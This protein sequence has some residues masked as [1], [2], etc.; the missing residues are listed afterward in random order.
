MTLFI[1]D[2]DGPSFILFSVSSFVIMDVI[3]LQ[4]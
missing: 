4:I 2:I 3:Y 1:F